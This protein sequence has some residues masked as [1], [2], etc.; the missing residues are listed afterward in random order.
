MKEITE[1]LS[2]RLKKRISIEVPTETAD[3][4]GGFTITWNNFASVWA[5]IIP[6]RG[7][8]ELQSAKIQ[9]VKNFKITIRYLSG[10]TT[11]MRINFGG[12]IFN[13]RAVMNMMEES[14]VTEIIAEEGV[15]I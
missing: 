10:I 2:S 14:S 13:I 7:R 11:K 1:N 9:E 4:A 15:A 8:E 5:E 6:L 12:R 3:G